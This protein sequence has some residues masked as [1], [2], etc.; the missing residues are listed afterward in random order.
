[1]A[2]GEARLGPT[3]SVR[4]GVPAQALL[5]EARALRVT[6]EAA[7]AAP[8]NRRRRARESFEAL[9]SEVVRHQLTAMP[10]ARLGETTQGRLRL[11]AIEAAGYDT[12]GAALALGRS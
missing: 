11:Q 4:P 1:V 12:V 10:I 5:E 3:V 7:L 9:R 6:I 8:A 2:Y